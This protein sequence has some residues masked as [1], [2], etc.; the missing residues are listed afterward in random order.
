MAK[1]LII[2]RVNNLITSLQTFSNDLQRNRDSVN[3]T[4]SHANLCIEQSLKLITSLK[5][6]K[7]KQQIF[8]NVT[9]N[10]EGDRVKVLLLSQIK[11]IIDINI[12][13]GQ[14]IIRFFLSMGKSVKIFSKRGNENEFILL[15]HEIKS[16]Y[17]DARSNLLTDTPETRYYY[18][19][20]VDFD[21]KLIGYSSE[22]ISIQV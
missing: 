3:I 5:A 17:H 2:D 13:G 7:N 4:L 21:G 15:T 19:Q 22:I 8:S 6:I 20:Y 11:P 16:P 14:L 10:N 18:A 12:T 1:D 9:A